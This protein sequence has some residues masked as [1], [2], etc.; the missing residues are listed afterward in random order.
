MLSALGPQAP[1]KIRD[2]YGNHCYLGHAHRPLQSTQAILYLML[3]AMICLT[4]FFLKCVHCTC[5][6]LLLMQNAQPLKWTWWSGCLA[7][8]HSQQLVGWVRWGLRETQ[9]CQANIASDLLQVLCLQ[10]P[11]KVKNHSKTNS[12]LRR[13]KRLLQSVQAHVGNNDLSKTVFPEICA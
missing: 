6:G 4:L 5:Q 9:G 3:T 12:C 2:H 10:V 7:S 13:A 1:E 11:G 8:G